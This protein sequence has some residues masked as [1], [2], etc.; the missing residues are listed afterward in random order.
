MP[1]TGKSL[2]NS[3]WKP[4]IRNKRCTQLTSVT[5]LDGAWG[6]VSVSWAELSTGSDSR[7]AAQNWHRFRAASHQKP[8]KGF[9][10]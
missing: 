3:N 2:H 6:S 5:K 9:A 7:Q 4:P 1:G 10:V 8:C